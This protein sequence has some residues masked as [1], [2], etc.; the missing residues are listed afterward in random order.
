MM[1]Y[2]NN[3]SGLFS[4]LALLAAVFVPIAVYLWGRKDRLQDMRDELDAMQGIDKFPLSE[5]NRERFAKRNY[6]EK[7]VNRK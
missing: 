4:L 3:Y 1:D 5:G 6:L 7:K 2:L